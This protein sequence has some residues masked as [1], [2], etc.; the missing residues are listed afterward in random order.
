MRL[1]GCTSSNILLLT[2][3]KGEVPFGRTQDLYT[4]P[5]DRSIFSCSHHLAQLFSLQKLRAGGQTFWIGW[6]LATASRRTRSDVILTLRL[7]RAL[8]A[9]KPKSL[10]FTSSF[11]V[12]RLADS[13]TSPVSTHPVA[14]TSAEGMPGYS[15][16]LIGRQLW[17]F[18][19]P[20]W[21]LGDSMLD[22]TVRLGVIGTSDQ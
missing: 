7:L 16:E 18:G 1:A 21:R 5:L 14:Y 2:L 3:S 6:R 11:S 8:V 20:V 19:A 17:P 12:S 22:A 4:D 10:P 13:A 15:I 9:Y